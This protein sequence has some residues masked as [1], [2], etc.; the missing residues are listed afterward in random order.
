MAGG[1]IDIA[2]LGASTPIGRDAWAS[3][4]AVRA[5]ISGFAQHPYMID[6]AGNPMRVAMAPWLDIGLTGIERF[7]ALLYPSIDQVLKPLGEASPKQTGI[8]LSLGLPSPRPG[9]AEDLQTGL[10]MALGQQYQGLF[11]A[12]AVFP[13]GHA[14]GLLA[15]QAAAKKLSQG[16]FDACVVAG[17][18]S[19][20]EPETLEWLEAC[21]Q[22]HGAGPLNNAWGFIPG[23][24]AS[25]ILLMR[26]EVSQRLGIA[27]LSRL[28]GLGSAVEAK[29]IKTETV[30]IG[31]GLTSAFRNALQ[32]L[33]EG[34]K[35]TDVYCDMNGEP[36]R[37][38]EYGFTCLRTKE[39][40]VSAADFIAPADCW[41]DVSAAGGL[42]HLGLA[43]IAGVKGYAN[44]E[45]AFVWASSEGGER[46]AAVL[47][48]KRGS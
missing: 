22:L 30:C 7:K 34:L 26:H 41:G 21:E 11:S 35:V 33:P 42:L 15:L 10:T 47:Q 8:A 1:P 5:G 12:V 27:P 14:A 19:Y 2:A 25:A 23:E 36:Y 16:A 28:L 31:E 45:C 48:V 43:S 44:G 6:T 37:G 3:A 39:F 13:S 29:R 24:A 18:D 4:A 17:V 9:L 46:A 32:G 20:M 40:F 38:D